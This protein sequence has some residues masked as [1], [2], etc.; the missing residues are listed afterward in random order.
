M[1]FPGG[2]LKVYVPEGVTK[3]ITSK[4]FYSYLCYGIGVL[5]EPDL[6]CKV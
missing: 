1:H 2:T 3:G 4:L 6:C 5:D